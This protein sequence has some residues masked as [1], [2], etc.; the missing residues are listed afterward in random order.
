[1]NQIDKKQ[2]YW[3]YLLIIYSILHLTRDI[4]Q[5]SGVK[6]FLSTIL[7]KKVNSPIANTILWTSLNTYII[8]IAEISLAIFCLKRKQFGRVGYLTV[9]IALITVFAWLLYW[10]YL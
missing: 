1:M 9:G 10:F 4:L 7:V 8:A 2:K 6:I 3:L 5:D